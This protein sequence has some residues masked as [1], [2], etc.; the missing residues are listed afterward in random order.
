MAQGDAEGLRRE[1]HVAVGE[2]QVFARG[3]AGAWCMAWVLP[4]QPAG[5]SWT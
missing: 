1:Q 2:H 4:S 3:L 5:K